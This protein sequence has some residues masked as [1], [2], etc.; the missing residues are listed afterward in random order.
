MKDSGLVVATKGRLAEVEVNCLTACQDCSAKS[1]C[2]AQGPN[3]G[4]LSAKNPLKALPGDRVTLEIPDGMYN[5]SLIIL[6]GSLLLAA[7]VGIA[8]GYFSAAFLP[9]SAS[10]GSIIGLFLGILLAA[11]WQFRRFRKKTN[12]RLFPTIT[13]IISKGGDHG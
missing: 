1:L 12:A 9:L 3:K 2:S 10:L 8:A 7:L 11:I 13:A 6:F 5:K 4:L